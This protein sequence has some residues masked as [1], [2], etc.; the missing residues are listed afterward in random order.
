MLQVKKK[1]KAGGGSIWLLKGPLGRE[2]V[3]GDPG[4]P[5]CHPQDTAGGRR[6]S[7]NTPRALMVDDSEGHW[8]L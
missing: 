8:Q 5:S 2:V 7:H 4:G 1:K 6:N 3:L